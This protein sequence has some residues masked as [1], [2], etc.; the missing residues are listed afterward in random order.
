MQG[1]GIIDTVSYRTLPTSCIE[2]W[3]TSSLIFSINIIIMHHH[4]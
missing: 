1:S 2:S 3:Y 4:K